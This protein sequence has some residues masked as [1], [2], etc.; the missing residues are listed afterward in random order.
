[1]AGLVACLSL[2]RRTS[3][4]RNPHQRSRS[5][6]L[7]LRKSAL[8]GRLCPLPGDDPAEYE[9]L[10]L[11]ELCEH[12]DPEDLTEDR[13]VR[14]MADAEWRLRRVRGYIELDLTRKIGELAP[15]DPAAAALELQAMAYQALERELAAW[16]RYESK[17]E[18]QYDRA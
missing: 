4:R 12:F 9:A 15:L 1:M 7:P 3:L 8:Q 17:F 13:C 2:F 6:W 5:R 10:L 14:E 16:T 18:R 11:D